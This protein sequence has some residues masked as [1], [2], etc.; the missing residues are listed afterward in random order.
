MFGFGKKAKAKA[1]A[2]QV[3]QQVVSVSTMF[4]APTPALWLDPYV[5]GILYGLIVSTSRYAVGGKLDPG[6]QGMIVG[7]VMQAVTGVDG[8]QMMRRGVSLMQERN[9]E[10]VLAVNRAATISDMMARQAIT[11]MSPEIESAIERSKEMKATSISLGTH[12]SDVA[13]VINELY[14]MWITEPIREKLPE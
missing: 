5:N 8:L 11:E 3:A 13:A 7:E 10:F 1:A 12:T 14:A 2:L 4:R 9:S 6:E